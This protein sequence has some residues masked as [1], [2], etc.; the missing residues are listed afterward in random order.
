MGEFFEKIILITHLS[1]V[2]EQF[3]G[4]IMVYMT[5]EQESKIQVMD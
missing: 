3:P 5:P 2:A 1:E 4:R